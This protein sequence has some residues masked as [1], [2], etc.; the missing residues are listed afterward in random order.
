MKPAA[1]IYA[2]VSTD[3]QEENYSL[4]SQIEACQRYA[5]QQGF[6]VVGVFQD[7]MSGAKI[8]RPNLDKVRQLVRQREIKAVVVY[9]SDRLTRNVAHSYVLRDELKRAGVALHYVT[10]G[11]SA[12]TAEGNLFDTMDS[13]FAEYER[14]KIAERMMRGKRQKVANGRLLGSGG[15]PYGFQWSG[16]TADPVLVADPEQAA[17]VQMIYNWYTVE[18]LGMERIAHRLRTL[19][20]PTQKGG[21]AQWSVSRIGDILRRRIYIGVYD[22]NW[23]SKHSEIVPIEG[24][25]EPIISLEQFEQAQRLRSRNKKYAQ[26]NRKHRYLL[27]HRIRSDRS[28]MSGLTTTNRL[29]NDFSYYVEFNPVRLG[30]DKAMRVATDRIEQAVWAAL[31]AM[32]TP[33]VVRDGLIAYRQRQQGDT[34]ARQ[35]QIATLQRERAS[36]EARHKKLIAAFEQDAI[37]IDDLRESKERTQQSI[38]SIDCELARLQQATVGL[39]TAAQERETLALVEQMHAALHDLDEDEQR[40]VID[41]LDVAVVVKEYSR[42]AMTFELTTLIGSMVVQAVKG[43]ELCIV[44]QDL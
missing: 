33:N 39:M 27:S 42:K 26:G 8:E 24:K 38:A 15:A 18:G 31:L 23:R 32:L 6:D 7:V 20:I 22:A 13:A 41:A 34:D 37:T 19:G 3:G 25:V 10:R 21:A 16:T 43:Q 30:N 4:P 14:L 44:S 5:E 28:G 1:A 35:Q 29:G 9:A 12:D 40:A 11:V 36:I 2:R 17:V